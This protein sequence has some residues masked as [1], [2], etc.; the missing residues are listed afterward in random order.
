MPVVLPF[1]HSKTNN[2]IIHLAKRLVEP[3]EFDR[4]RESQDID[5]LK[6]LMQY[7]E[8]RFIWIC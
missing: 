7:I 3:L 8:P 6:G 5:Y 4:F 2:G 1:D